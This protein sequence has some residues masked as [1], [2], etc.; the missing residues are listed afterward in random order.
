MSLWKPFRATLALGACG[1]LT[2]AGCAAPP[3]GQRPAP[4][5]VGSTVSVIDPSARVHVDT[6][7]TVAD[8]TALAETVTNK[9]L[10]SRLVRQWQK[11]KRKPRLIVATPVNNTDDES[12]RVADIFDRISEVLLNSGTVRIM[13]P[14]ANRFDYIVRTELSTTRQMGR[15]GEELAY[16]K[17]ELKLF[18][19][20]GEMVGQ[21]SDVIPL[22]RPARSFLW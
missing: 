11:R 5:P 2:L 8:Y 18:T 3:R 14:E 4:A 9:M 6:A 22:A 21:W 1:I 15:R 19:D 17:L 20:D 10:A 16:F 12:I 7:L 13:M